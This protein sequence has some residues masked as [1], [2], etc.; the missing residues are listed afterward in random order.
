[1][2]ITLP[3]DFSEFLRLLDAHR[4]EYLLV[5]GYAVAHHG[6]PRATQDLDVWVAISAGQDLQAHGRPDQIVRMGLPEAGPR[7]STW[8]ALSCP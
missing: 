5:G 6:Y 3:R 2:A 4:V 8:T 1:M 7:R